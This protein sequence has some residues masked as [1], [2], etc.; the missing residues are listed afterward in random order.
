MTLNTL[1]SDPDLWTVDPACSIHITTNRE[2]FVSLRPIYNI[3]ITIANGKKKRTE[4]MGDVVV[5]L[6]TYK[7][8]I[9]QVYYVPGL[10]K[11]VNFLSS[12]PLTG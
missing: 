2:V 3:S 11:K 9:H 8:S 7:T 1:D 12:A 5:E 4:G 10:G 6:G